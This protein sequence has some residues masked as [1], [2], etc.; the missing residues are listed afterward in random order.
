MSA[1]RSNNSAAWNN[2]YCVDYAGSCCSVGLSSSCDG[3]DYDFEC[4][5]GQKG[6]EPWMVVGAGRR[7]PLVL[8]SH[9]VE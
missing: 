1:I 2:S 3:D 9:C 4:F 5:L 8:N 6:V 7:P